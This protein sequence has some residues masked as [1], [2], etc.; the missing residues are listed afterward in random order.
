VVA[1]LGLWHNML[2]FSCL[3]LV[4]HPALQMQV[5]VITSLLSPGVGGDVVPYGFA[6]GLPGGSLSGGNTPLEAI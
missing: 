4:V 3:L 6:P 5:V 1:L 2:M